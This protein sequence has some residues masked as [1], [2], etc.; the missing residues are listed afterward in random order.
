MR[1]AATLRRLAENLRKLAADADEATAAEMFEIVD[2][3][4]TEAQALEADVGLPMPMP[5]PRA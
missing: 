1:D 4:E 2:A 3:Y 5:M